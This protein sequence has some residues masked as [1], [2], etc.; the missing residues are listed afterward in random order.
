MNILH[1][2]YLDRGGASAIRRLHY[3]LLD[4]GYNS[5]LLTADTMSETRRR[6]IFYQLQSTENLHFIDKVKI[7]LGLRSPHN[8]Y[9]TQGL[10]LQGHQLG[11]GFTFPESLEDI[12][13]HQ[14]Y[15][16]AHIIHLHWVD[17][18]INY[19]VFFR[20]NT[21]PVVWTLH[22]MHAFTGG[23]HYSI[24][25]NY[26]AEQLIDY[27]QPEQNNLD[28]ILNRNITIKKQ[29]IDNQKI[30]VIPTTQKMK[31]LSEKS[32]IFKNFLHE[33]IPL[34]LDTNIFK[35]YDKIM[36]RKLFD[37]PKE[38]QVLVF[39]SA[40]LKNKFKGL[41][42]LVEALSKLENPP[43]LLAIGQ[44]NNEL[45][46]LPYIRFTDYI[47]DEKLMAMAYSAGDCFVTP[48][49]QEAFG[50]T[51]IEAMACGLPVISFETWGALDLID[52]TNGIIVKSLTSNGLK[53]AIEA[54]LVQKVHFCSKTIRAKTVQ[55]Y[56]SNVLINAHIKLYERM[57][58]L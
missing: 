28:K 2:S 56:D 57:L 34:G 49:L 44:K 18:M 14:L 38:A 12:T 52:D 4:N 1:I 54:V 24:G 22:D 3:G 13:K 47:L 16:K 26:E 20:K 41:S 35:P 42:I 37:I 53:D 39:V 55:K 21:K 58:A 5:D 51:T 31:Q 25:V 29:S 23:L 32:Q 45:I 7:K 30:M 8:L 15:Q 11:Y 9:D 10:Q 40:D 46:Q 33:L 17:K 6:K 27:I 50:Q 43:Y 36:C 19:P 48:S